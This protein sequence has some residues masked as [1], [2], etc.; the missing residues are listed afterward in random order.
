[1]GVKSGVTRAEQMLKIRLLNKR[2]VQNG[3]ARNGE[4]APFLCPV[5]SKSSQ[6]ENSKQLA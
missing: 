3:M 1:M 2:A 5:F 4:H 6:V